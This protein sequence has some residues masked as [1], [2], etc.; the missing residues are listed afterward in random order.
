[1]LTPY[2]VG[3]YSYMCA[4]VFGDTSISVDEVIS[5]RSFYCLNLNFWAIF[6]LY[7]T[8]K[9]NWFKRKTF[10]NKPYPNIYI[11]NA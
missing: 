9:H 5:P 4:M 1:M 6:L 10:V 7:K 8:I 11:L 2:S 3:F